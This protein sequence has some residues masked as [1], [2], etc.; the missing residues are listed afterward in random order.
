MKTEID[1]IERDFNKRQKKDDREK[2]DRV[3]RREDRHDE[4]PTRRA[5]R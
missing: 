1:R 5:R 4:N 3:R 2:L